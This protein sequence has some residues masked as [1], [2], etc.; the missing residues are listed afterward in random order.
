MSSIEK[1]LIDA[2]LSSIEVDAYT[3]I[4][5]N[6]PIGAGKVAKLTYNYRANIYQA[7]ERLKSKGFVSE[8][9]GKKSKLFE[10]MA[11]NHILSE[12]TR[13]KESFQKILPALNQMKATSIETT[14]MRTIEGIHGW[15]YLLDEFID[16]G[17]E[18]VVY[19]IPKEAEIL[20]D[21]F[22]TYHQKRAKNK[23]ALR[24]LFNYDARDRIK[25]T[26]SLPFTKS[27]YLPKELKQ[28]VSTSICGSIVALTVYKKKNI[29][30][31]VI[32]NIT[33]ANAYREY[34]EF[35]WKQGKE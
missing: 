33:I 18:R 5:T 28:P 22:K 20:H 9:Q 13:K 31:I 11:P 35:L 34:F 29:S 10:A 3:T 1:S 32:D 19:G 16:T 21:F 26:R 23:I 6:G 4:L 2:G 27:K 7:I 12:L 24:H 15:K 30:T 14:S 8:T 25:T 17:E